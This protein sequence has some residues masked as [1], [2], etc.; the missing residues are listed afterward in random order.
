MKGEGE[1]CYERVGWSSR[2][3]WWFRHMERMEEGWLVKDTI[4]SDVRGRTRT[5]WMDGVKSVE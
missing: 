4:G 3:C 1:R 2:A 5:G